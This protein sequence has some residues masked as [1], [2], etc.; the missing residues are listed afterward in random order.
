[1]GVPRALHTDAL[2]SLKNQRQKRQRFIAPAACGKM[3]KKPFYK[4]F[5]A[6]GG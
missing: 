6:L 2:F 5:P 4:D 1:M 3:K